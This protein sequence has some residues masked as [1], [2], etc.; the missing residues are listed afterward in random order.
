[1]NIIRDVSESLRKLIYSAMKT[2]LESIEVIVFDSPA[3]IRDIKSPMISLFLYM[4][5]EYSAY[6][7]LNTPLENTI[8]SSPMFIKL[9][10][11]ITPYA[12]TKETEQILLAKILAITHDSPVLS[13][14][15]LC[16]CLD[17]TGNQELKLVYE[18]LSL[19][20]FNKIWTRLVGA[21][22]RASLSFTVEPV[23]IPSSKQV[24]IQKVRAQ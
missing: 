1:M 15:K 17:E 2:E 9:H 6:Q 19:A 20:D 8:T 22:Y 21:D 7:S 14:S 11:L 4:V 3:E 18:S 24:E 13:G 5:S 12:E 23:Q 16:G 10:Y